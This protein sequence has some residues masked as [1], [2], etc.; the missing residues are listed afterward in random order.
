MKMYILLRKC[1]V[2]RKSFHKQPVFHHFINFV[3]RKS[4]KWKDFCQKAT[5]F[6][7]RISDMLSTHDE[8]QYGNI[9]INIFITLSLSPN[10]PMHLLLS[11]GNNIGCSIIIY[12]KGKNLLYNI[13][14]S[15][16]LPLGYLQCNV[17]SVWPAPSV[18][19]MV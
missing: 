15:K 10:A 5:D 16:V 19:F 1:L 7:F 11:H 17:L 6:G 4:S 14:L 13:L 2:S 9:D 8:R 12:F 3:V 18:Y